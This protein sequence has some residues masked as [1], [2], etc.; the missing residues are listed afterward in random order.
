[1]TIP[2][3]EDLAVRIE[4]RTNLPRDTHTRLTISPER[5]AAFALRIRIPVWADSAQVTLNG[6]REPGGERYLDLHARPV[7]TSRPQVKLGRARPLT[8]SGGGSEIVDSPLVS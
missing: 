2:L 8:W 6:K 7:T 4:Q 1:M 5:E 3:R